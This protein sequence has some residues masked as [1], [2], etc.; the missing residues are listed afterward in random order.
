MLTKKFT[1]QGSFKMTIVYCQPAEFPRLIDVIKHIYR[2]NPVGP[3]QHIL[4]QRVADT[5]R[6]LKFF[7]ALTIFAIFMFVSNSVYELVLKSEKILVMNVLLPYV[8]HTT[9]TGFALTTVFHT[10]VAAFGISGNLAF[11]IYMQF[12]VCNQ[13]TMIVLWKD[14]LGELETMW[15]T[16]ERN[17]VIYRRAYLRNMLLAFQETDMWVCFLADLTDIL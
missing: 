5:Y 3:R 15:Q 6:M 2:A 1:E 12:M 13:R 4:C 11:D 10:I 16:N 8:D 9:N 17:T 7:S 14:A